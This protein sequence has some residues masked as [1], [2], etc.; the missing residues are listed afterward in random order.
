MQLSSLLVV[1]ATSVPLTLGYVT[2]NDDSTFS[3]PRKNPPD[4]PF[5]NPVDGI[6]FTL[7]QYILAVNGKRFDFFP[8][9]FTPDVTGRYDR[10]IFEFNGTED[11]ARR[12]NET[13]VRVTAQHHLSTQ[14]I[15]LINN[16]HAYAVTYVTEYYFGVKGDKDTSHKYFITG[17]Y[18]DELKRANNE[19][20]WLIYHRDAGLTGPGFGEGAWI[21]GDNKTT[22]NS[23]T[24]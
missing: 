3:Q 7:A 8:Q 20:A 15:D 9:V 6:R 18:Q 5:A 23:A 12:L 10:P 17:Q 11:L 21:Y 1:L 4:Y 22:G 14:S 19:S 24:T 13:L 16:T 2:P